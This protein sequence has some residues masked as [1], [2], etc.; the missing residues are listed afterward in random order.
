MFTLEG[1]AAHSCGDESRPVRVCVWEGQPEPQ[2]ALNPICISPFACTL[3]LPARSD[4]VWDTY[5]PPTPTHPLTQQ[6]LSLA[7]PEPGTFLLEK[8]LGALTSSPTLPVLSSYA[9][10]CFLDGST[11]LQ[12]GPGQLSQFP[13]PSKAPSSGGGFQPVN[14]VV[15]I[16]GPLD[17][18]TQWW[19]WHR[20]SGATSGF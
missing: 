1:L 5:R 14:H 12:W 19:R 7:S 11:I 15:C 9:R 8:E 17:L 18:P 10:G 4:A 13:T 16:C 6:R 20:P 2:R 3:W